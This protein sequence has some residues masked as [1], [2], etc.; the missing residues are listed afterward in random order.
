MAQIIKVQ[1]SQGD[2][3]MA[4]NEGAQLLYYKEYDYFYVG[5]EVTAKAGQYAVVEANGYLK[6]VKIV[7]VGKYSN[8]ATKYAISIFDLQD[9]SERV[10]K[11]KQIQG[12]K[13]NILA[14]AEEARQMRELQTLAEG[15]S[16]LKEMLTELQTLESKE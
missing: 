16:L 9:H 2:T 1:F 10:K 8:K 12:L 14:R 3:H 5:E 11:D 13:E 15:D 6:V 7:G 4:A